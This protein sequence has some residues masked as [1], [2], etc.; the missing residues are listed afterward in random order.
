M[1][2]PLLALAA[3]VSM[4]ASSA[5]AAP[6]RVMTIEKGK[7]KILHIAFE[8]TRGANSNPAVLAARPDAKRKRLIFEARAVGDAT[9]TVHEGTE[10][11]A[12][13][14]EVHVR[15]IDAPVVTE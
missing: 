7:L 3:L 1:K 8:P 10:E 9:Y 2:R 15:V 6:D 12:R 4:F 11:G 13:R 14:L 5:L